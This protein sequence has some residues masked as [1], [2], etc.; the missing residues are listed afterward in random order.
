MPYLRV[1]VATWKV[2]LHQAEGQAL[3]QQ[4]RWY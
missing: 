4:S 2:D 3:I 1:S